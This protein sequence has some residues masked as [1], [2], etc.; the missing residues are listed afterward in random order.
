MPYTP[1]HKERTRQRILESARCVFNKKGVSEATI[2]EIM[3]SAGLSH[4]GFTTTLTARLSFALRLPQSFRS[5][6]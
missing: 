3:A 6:R 5:R 4:G 2:G 1:P